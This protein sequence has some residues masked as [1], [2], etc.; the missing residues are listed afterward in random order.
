MMSG[1]LMWT[2]HVYERWDVFFFVFCFLFCF[3]FSGVF[4]GFFFLIIVYRNITADFSLKITILNV[5]TNRL[6]DE[7]KIYVGIA[8]L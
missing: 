2:L 5:N 7:W 8:C 1:R 3:D 4:W 6:T